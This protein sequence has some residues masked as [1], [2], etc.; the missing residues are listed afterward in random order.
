MK[1]LPLSIARA[2][3]NRI[4]DHVERKG[5]VVTVTRRGRPV[6][7]II[8]KNKYDSWQETFE[9]LSDTEFMNEIRDGIRTLKRTKK[10]YT[11][12]ELFGN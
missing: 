2:K 10:R 12:D 4:L 5:E 3:L 1:F 7:V 6:A 9:V 11:L 8:G